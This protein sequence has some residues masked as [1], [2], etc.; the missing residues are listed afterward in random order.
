MRKAFL[1][2]YITLLSCSILP[3]IGWGGGEDDPKQAP[4]QTAVGE[5]LDETTDLLV[6]FRWW[7]LIGL[8]FFPQVRIAIGNFLLAVFQAAQVPFLMIRA[9]YETRKSATTG[10]GSSSA[11]S[12][13][14]S[15][16]AG[17]WT[18]PSDTSNENESSET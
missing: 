13:S 9:W 15:S 12:G 2:I 3:D 11:S 7:L 10:S 8:L 1:L 4:P 17:P 18:P 5:V 16:S 14:S 6:E